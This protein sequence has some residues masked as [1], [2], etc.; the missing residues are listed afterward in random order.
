MKEKKDLRYEIME[1]PKNIVLTELK[2]FETEFEKKKIHS[3]RARPYHSI[4]FRL[5]GTISVEWGG[6]RML[7]G[8]GCITWIPKGCSYDT[9]ILETGTMICVQ[10]LMSEERITE[11]YVLPTEKTA[12]FQTLF[13]MLK[14]RYQP[15]REQDYSCL[16]TMYQILARMEKESRNRLEP[17]VP[18]RMTGARK[19]IEKNFEQPI[20]VESLAA[21]AGISEAYFRMEFKRYFGLTPVAYLKKVRIE[22]AKVMLLSGYYTVTQVASRCGFDSVSYFS[23]EFHRSTGLTPREYQNREQTLF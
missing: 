14:D 1:F 9:E 7:S 5:T 2:V 21:D 20:S 6:K 12:T 8:P 13:D 18:A 3:V 16:A 17:T 15:G 4:T 19:Y 23:A 22:N 11:P 10:F